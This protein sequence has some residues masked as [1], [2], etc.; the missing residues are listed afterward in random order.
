MGQLTLGGVDELIGMGKESA[1]GLKLDGCLLQ[2]L[3]AK[4][5]ELMEA[6]QKRQNERTELK[7]KEATK[8]R[9]NEHKSEIEDLKARIC[10]RCRNKLP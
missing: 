4:Q 1:M 9:E 3:L 10:I 7:H 5:K 6:R 8:V 2:E